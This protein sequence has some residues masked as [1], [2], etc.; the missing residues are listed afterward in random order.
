MFVRHVMTRQ[1]YALS[2]Q[3]S[4]RDAYQEFRTRHIRRA[5]V[6]EYGQLVGIVT[7]HD[8]LRVLPGTVSQEETQA[9]HF[10]WELQIDRN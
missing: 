5:P 2:R 7:L 4:C 8:L 3:V 6:V 9:G 10:A 1:V